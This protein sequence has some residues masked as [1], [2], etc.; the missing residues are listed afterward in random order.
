MES[1]IQQIAEILGS[2]TSKTV[3]EYT[4]WYFISAVV[5]ATF[6]G[7]V[8]LS[9]FFYKFEGGFSKSDQS[10]I[11]VVRFVLLF[12]AAM[13]FAL[14]ITNLIAPEAYAIHQLFRDIFSH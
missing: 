11:R 5:W 6:W 4:R 12:F 8:A 1:E 3:A 7:T 9:L 14:N 13:F 10:W 2:S